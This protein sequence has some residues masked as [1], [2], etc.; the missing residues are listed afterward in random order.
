MALLLHAPYR[1]V[2]LA[3]LALV[4]AHQPSCLT[5]PE[6]FH[7]QS[8]LAH[9]EEVEARPEVTKAHPESEDPEA[10]RRLGLQIH[11][12]RPEQSEAEVE[13]LAR[14]PEVAVEAHRGIRGAASQHHH[15]L[16]PYR[17]RELLASREPV[18]EQAGCKSGSD[19]HQESAY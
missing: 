15:R 17:E 11:L 19:A 1:V 14:R 5:D 3:L 6:E 12:T 9:P 7:H 16:R 2:L 8:R 18:R 10:H 4:E 13:A